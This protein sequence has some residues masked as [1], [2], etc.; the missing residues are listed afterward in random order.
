MMINLN[1]RSCD[2]TFYHVE[3]SKYW[4][5]SLRGHGMAGWARTS[6]FAAHRILRYNLLYRSPPYIYRWHLDDYHTHLVCIH[7]LVLGGKNV[8]SYL[9]KK[10]LKCCKIVLYQE[11]EVSGERMSYFCHRT[12]RICLGWHSTGSASL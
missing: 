8:V 1:K 2:I 6:T 12:G 3:L 10:H 11:Y 7:R 4:T 5:R 9:V